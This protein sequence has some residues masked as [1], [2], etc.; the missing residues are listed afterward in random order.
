MIPE[1]DWTWFNSIADG[2]S[3]LS[4]SRPQEAVGDLE[5]CPPLKVCTVHTN[6]YFH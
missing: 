6:R 3:E 1:D 2:M 5:T 4:G